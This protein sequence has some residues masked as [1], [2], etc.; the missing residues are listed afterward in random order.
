MTIW[1]P[2]IDS[3]SGPRYRA[4]ALA[5]GEAIQRGELA[6]GT[7][8]PPQRHLADVLGVTVGTVTRGYA[9]AEHRGWVTARVGSGTYVKPLQARH[10]F[11]TLHERESGL[12]D[13]SLSLPP[14]HP[15]RAQALSTALQALSSE[16]DVLKRGITYS[17]AQGSEHHRQLLARWLGR[18][19]MAL[20]ADELLVTQ[21]GQHAISLVLST[22]LR[23][24]ELVAADALTYPGA[25]SAAQQAHLKMVGIPFDQEGMSMA[26]LEAQCAR[27]P[28][29]LIYLTPDQNN[30]TGTCLSEE[31]RT[32]LVAL[33]RRYDIWLLEDGVQ[34]L[35]VE[36]RG[37]PLYQLAPE[38]TL[39][40]FS[41]AKVLAGGLRIGVLRAPPALL[42][43]LAA[44]VRAQSWM[45]PPLMVD[46]V[47]HWIAQ[48]AASE[49]LAWQTGEL[50]ARQTLAEQL[51]AGY[52]LGRR[53]SGSNVWLALPEGVRALELCTRLQQEGVKVE[54]A[55][56]FC[57]GS[58]P[59]PQAI[60]ICIGAAS[61]QTALVSA[62]NTVRAS[63][64]QPP[65]A[66]TTV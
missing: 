9:E 10:V 29:R 23:P 42:E 7:R 52:A 2:H 1:V 14:P 36:Q 45:V 4:I 18:L 35:P 40:V 31:R 41:T 20:A 59:A 49:L 39:F 22:L 19:G 28:P 5:I 33:A 44:G 15:L 17:G 37:T 6:P 56:P 53:P 3:H 27:Q 63:L 55:E 47:C 13:L 25:I 38:R 62:L 30:P 12:T 48:P 11:D 43:R 34:Y 64:A 50:T 65:L 58:A 66:T 8:L 32:Q 61:D 54:S 51:L 46:V 26:A 57:V 16:P 24:G 21:G 60:R